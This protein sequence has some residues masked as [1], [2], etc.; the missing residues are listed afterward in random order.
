[1]NVNPELLDQMFE[2]RARV[3]GER[4]G[5]NVK[6]IDGREL[7]E[8]DDLQ[9]AYIII[10][11]RGRVVGS[12]R[13][14]PTTGRT[15]LAEH[16]PEVR[17]AGRI[18]KWEATRFCVDRPEIVP[19]LGGLM[20]AYG[21]AHDIDSFVGC[22]DYPTWR[23]YRAACKAVDCRLDILGTVKRQGKMIYVGEFE[24]SPAVLAKLIIRK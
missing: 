19:A 5:W 20:T 17:C 13:L 10:A 22:F 14:M 24:V 12:V 6:V 15:M 8:Y 23:I 16:F 9:P 4:L 11:D 3:F 2:Q 1:M 21:L 7:D 18:G